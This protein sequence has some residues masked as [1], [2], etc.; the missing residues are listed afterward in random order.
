MGTLVGRSAELARL[1]ALLDD[2]ASGAV[3]AL[4]AGDAGVGKSRL[5]TEVTSIAASQ[6]FTVLCGQCAEIGDSVPYL[7]FADAI[8][9]ASAEVEAAVKARPVLARLLPDGGAGGDPETD[10]AGLTRQQ[11][12]GTVLGLLAELSAHSP[13]LLVL[14]DL[15]WADASTRDLLTFLLR[16]L[17]GER[18]AIIG[19]YRTDDLYRRH[20]LRPVVADLLRLPSVTSV[21]L[22]PLSPSALTELLF[23]ISD[24][25]GRLSAATVNRIV[26]SA[27]GNAY[28]AEEL[29]AALSDAPEDTRNG[30]G[31]PSGLAAL[32]MSRVERVSDAA[33][34]VLRAASVA[35]RRSGDDLVRAASGLPDAAYDE[36]VREAVA[37]QLLVPDGADGYAFRH[38]LLREAV[39]SD[40]LPGERTRLHGQLAALLSDVPGAAA[41]L[42]HHSLASHDVPGAFAAS[43]RAGDEARR[44]GAP[45]ET[46]RHYDQALSLW[47]RVDDAAAI[48][49]VSRGRLGLQSAA[50][51]FA[52]G[53]VPRAVHLLRRIWQAL[54]DPGAGVTAG[55]EDPEML[56][57]HIGERLAYF[58]L[59][60]ESSDAPAEALLVAGDTVGET[61][62][63]PATWYVARAMAT[64]AMAFMVAGDD[65]SAREWAQRARDAAGGEARWVAAEA[66]TTLGALSSREG[67]TDEASRMF[68]AALEQAGGTQMFQVELRATYLLAEQHQ[69]RGELAEAARIA[70]LGERRADSEGLGLAPYGMDLRHLHFQARFL[71]GEWDHA[72][73]L[74]DG[75][76]VRVT[77]LPEAVLSGMALFIDVARGNP[78]AE[79]RRTW[80]EPF[81][82]DGFVGYLV[83]GLLA[84]RALW[85]GDTDLALSHAEAAIYAD[86]WRSYK[87]AV[88]RPA[89][90][91]L[92]ARA[93]RAVA[94]RAAG[95]ADVE[96]AEL[97]GAN[98]LI[99]VARQG[100]RHP[101]HPKALLGPEGRGW[102]ARAEAEY[103]R[104]SGH[105]TPEAWEAMLSAFG[106]HYVYETARG[107]WRLAE[108]LIE[109]GRTEEALPVWRAAAA[110]ATHLGAA[111]LSA[112]LEILARRARLD[113]GS[114]PAE[115]GAVGAY[116]TEALTDRERDVLRL[117]ARGQSNRQIGAEL[118]ISPKTAS[119]HVSNILAKLAVTNRTE[120][121]AVAHR[122]GL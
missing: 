104:A 31:L 74:A 71:L 100:A 67:D 37:N 75:F 116:L 19:T 26:A 120:A 122:E 112:A 25:P 108:A 35:G 81:W 11:M 14:E 52:A 99:D 76:P 73:R 49:G 64:Y 57:S 24:A 77:S 62:A 92:A 22:G 42:A 69:A 59:E 119:V 72:Q 4:V 90:I 56:R 95:N 51:A 36:A 3:A 20:P 65:A 114:G 58:L 2:A 93:D 1:R 50:A 117:L 82:A 111:P 38:A 28:Y 48:A 32:L 63:E 98:E 101:A 33:Q 15:H 86:K 109:A 118:F 87:P 29:L 79:E 85:R 12:F 41:E 78:A 8:R 55:D 27:E 17:H 44:L 107:Q 18:V 16:M 103:G 110:T 70:E 96:A 43:I 23:A 30:P 105:N 113:P 34:R 39:Y 83:R 106:P 94:A 97:A 7:P 61:S 45:T 66:L 9:T 53:D 21:Q 47:D 84:E 46:H 5:V 10:R 89:A 54:A 40:L 102:L 80:L 115:G 13:V 121:A 6:G 91:A 88:L 68:A 60:S